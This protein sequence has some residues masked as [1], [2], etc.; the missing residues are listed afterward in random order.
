MVIISQQE[1]IEQNR[2]L[3]EAYEKM[4]EQYAVCH[5]E[6]RAAVEE[7]IRVRR[8]YDVAQT[9]LK[10]AQSEKKDLQERLEGRIED[11]KGQLDRVLADFQKATEKNQALYHQ[12]ED[13]STELRSITES[14][15]WRWLK[16]YWRLRDWIAKRP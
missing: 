8:M 12:L 10:A 11:L 2:I 6:L 3:A 4:A 7:T 5:D 9:E 14:R 13:R 1:I 16:R 15:T